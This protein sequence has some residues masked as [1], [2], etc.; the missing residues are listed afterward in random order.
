MRRQRGIFCRYPADFRA[1]PFAHSS[2]IFT[3]CSSDVDRCP[4]YVMLDFVSNCWFRCRILNIDALYKS[5]YLLYDRIFSQYSLLNFLYSLS[6]KFS[7]ILL[8]CLHGYVQFLLQP[9]QNV[10][11]RQI[12]FITRLDNFFGPAFGSALSSALDRKRV[13]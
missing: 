9:S 1:S 13:V 4:L 11:I 6:A 8:C 7:Q 12:E 3:D 5:S 10:I 2:T